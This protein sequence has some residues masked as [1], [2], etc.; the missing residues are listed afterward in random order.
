M[1]CIEVT[2]CSTVLG[3]AKLCFYSSVKTQTCTCFICTAFVRIFRFCKCLALQV[4]ETCGR[5]ADL[6]SLRHLEVVLARR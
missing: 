1:A 6:V 5:I 4:A 2:T 3:R